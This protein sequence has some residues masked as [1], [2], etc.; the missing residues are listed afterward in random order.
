LLPQTVGAFFGSQIQLAG[1]VIP[2]FVSD[3]SRH[4][5]DDPTSSL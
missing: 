1:S 2:T 3:A 4:S 5:A